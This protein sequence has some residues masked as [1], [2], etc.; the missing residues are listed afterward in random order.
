MEKVLRPQRFDT[1]PNAQDAARSW[2]HWFATFQNFVAA[3]PNEEVNKLKVLV[4]YVS[5]DVYQ[6][7]CEATTYE[8]AIELLKNLYV[9]VPNE[10]FSR[11]KLA[12]RKQQSGESL[13]EYLQ[14]LKSLSKDCNFRSVTSNQYRDEAVR[15]AFIAGLLS[16]N[17]RQR[18]LENKTLDLQTAFDQARALDTAQRTSETY[19]D[20]IPITAAAL[21]NKDG[22]NSFINQRAFENQDKTD[23][24]DGH[25]ENNGIERY[26]AASSRSAK[27]FFCGNRP[28]HRSACPAKDAYCYKCKKKGHFQRVCKS[29]APQAS[30]IALASTKHTVAKSLKKAC[31][32]VLINGKS[33][34]ALI[35][36]GSTHNFIHPKVAS[37][38]GLNIYTTQEKVTM[39]ASSFSSKIQGYCLADII[40]KEREYAKVKLFVL[41]NLCTNV[42]LGQ[43]WQE[44]HESII[45]EY[46]G[47]SPSLTI[48]GLSTI[49]I[50]PPPLFQF[51]SEDC[52]PVA[53]K[54]RRYSAEDR[55]FI[56]TEVSK[57]L[58]E[59]I[60]EES[61]SPWRAQV[62]VTKNER[63]KKRLV[64]D[65]SETI[66]KFTQLDAYPMPRIDDTVNAV[67]QYSVFSTVDLKSAYH[68]VPIKNKER[69]YTAFEAN[70]R[71]YQFRKIPFGVTNG[72]AA[73]QRSMDTFISEEALEDTF[74]YLDN[75][76]ICGYNQEHH[77]K[78]LELFMKAARKRNLTFNESKC[79]FSVTS[80]SILGSVVSQGEIKPDPERLKPLRELPAPRDAKA[81]KR[82]IGLFSYYSQWIKD[83]S[84]KIRPLSHNLAFP[85]SN[86]A[87]QAF[88][89]LKNDIENAVVGSI[90]ESYPFQIETDASEFALSATLN[91]QGRPV[92][93]F[94][95]ALNGSELKH[96]SVEKEA[97]AIVEAV[98][99]WKH[100]LTG[101]HFK[102]VT[103]QRSVAYMFNLKRHG[104]IKNDKIMRWR[105]ELSMYDFDI[106]YRTGEE[107][108][109]A[110]TLSRV[111]VMSLTLDK[112]FELH[113]ALCHPGVSRMS[114]FVKSRNLPFSI[115]EI[116]RMT[117]SC[118]DCRECKPQY[119]RP[120][121][122][123]LIKATQPFERL[124]VDFKGPLPSTDKKRYILTIIDEYS[125]FPFAF[126]CEDVSAR[127][128]VACLSEL[129]SV[130]G[131]P[132]YIHSDRGSGF[133]SAELKSFLLQKGISSSRT[134]SY[135]PAGNGQVEKFNGTLWKT[136]CLA[137]RSK[138]LPINRWQEVMLDALHSIRSLLCTATN[139]TPHERL[140][141]FQRK[142]TS[143][144]SVPS[145]LATPGKVLLKRQARNSKFEPL[146][147]EVHLIQANPQ[148]AHIRHADGREDTVSTKYLAPQ[149]DL[150]FQDGTTTSA[151]PIEVQDTTIRPTE[152]AKIEISTPKEE[153]RGTNSYDESVEQQS[154]QLRRSERRRRAPDRLTYD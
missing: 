109:P 146:V 38:L 7:F 80:I 14:E 19:A 107:N 108:I 128:I 89:L 119:Y 130:F 11:H 55:A 5:A 24:S 103:D 110:D 140:F 17:I 65:Y 150:G 144:V 86:D 20:G 76:T 81:Q 141:S 117:E 39:A 115:E 153:A 116:K 135:N 32:D 113:K 37:N 106:V 143:G 8:E 112:L 154:S 59:G 49:N 3:I 99:R 147:D 97:A 58:E 138:N 52:R 124:N 73:F 91:Q 30:Y 31:I 34:E 134:T 129:F 75:I 47:K 93:F 13:D 132:T 25:Q 12:T 29:V 2:L 126:P 26:V 104:K 131:M 35:D 22:E 9:K 72:A 40:L 53:A 6:L 4:N 48:C 1:N 149:G 43:N 33:C 41:T 56:A 23:Q 102:L 68:Q 87:L 90:D 78:N 121:Q 15:D 77:D 137:L 21:S 152:D 61:D 67:A 57:L 69:K 18:L 42:I 145:W 28:H 66:N 79:V 54:S 101:K 142:S 151:P 148:Y 127:T 133:M 74:A 62:V 63:Q 45:I 85:L 60:I 136:V 120:A 125:R 123:H 114:H 98:R 51:L 84:T 50:G 105:L 95:R 27:C 111:K 71:L 10:I 44:K 100:Y 118:R 88:D 36:S 82:V 16:T 96:S 70:H 46:G 64:I 94:S 139:A 92:A 122:S 83:F